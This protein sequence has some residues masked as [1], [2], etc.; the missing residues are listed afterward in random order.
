[1]S[2]TVL[3]L[4]LGTKTGWARGRPGERPHQWLHGLLNLTPRRFDGGGMRFVRFEQQLGRLLPGIDMVVYEEV[5]RHRGVDAAH[6]YGG[7]QGVMTK[8]CERLAVP[9]EG[10]PVGT[11]KRDVTGKGNTS[12]ADTI[13]FVHWKYSVDVRT[14]DEADAICMLAWA[15]AREEYD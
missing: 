4:D 8:E 13:H 15:L 5:R 2:R 11:W 10:V 7:L 3:A 1:M 9:Y 12:K 14:S 6:I